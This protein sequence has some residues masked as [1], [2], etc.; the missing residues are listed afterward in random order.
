[1]SSQKI[2]KPKICKCGHLKR[3]HMKKPNSFLKLTGNC[4]NCPC[5]EYF[6]RNR[7]Y[8][9][10]KLLAVLMPIL[11]LFFVG[12]TIIFYVEF[13]SM[14]EEQKN[15]SAGITNEI[16]LTFMFMMLLLVIVFLSTAF[17]TEPISEY[18]TA[19]NRRNYPI[20]N[21]D[22]TLENDGK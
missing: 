6:N 7:P 17:L 9:S 20:Q 14:T 11:F 15:A 13:Q 8:K 4:I 19:K 22:G 1:M 21:S 5:S 16:F 18:R 10:D 3:S 12:T 2:K